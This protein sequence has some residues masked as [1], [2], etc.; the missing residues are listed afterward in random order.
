VTRVGRFLASMMGMR[1]EVEPIASSSVAIR[2]LSHISKLPT[3]QNRVVGDVEA[4]RTG[5]ERYPNA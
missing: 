4:L 3:D 5:A 1:G 2:D